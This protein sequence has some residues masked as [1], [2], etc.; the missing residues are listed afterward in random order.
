[1]VDIQTDRTFRVEN[2]IAIAVKTDR[3]RN[4]P[5]K[6]VVRVLEEHDITLAEM[7][8]VIDKSAEE[9]LTNVGIER[10][11]LLKE[12]EDMEKEL[13]EALPTE[14]DVKSLQ[15]VKEYLESEKVRKCMQLLNKQRAIKQADNK[16]AELEKTAADV[17]AWKQQME[18]L[19]AEYLKVNQIP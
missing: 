17:V 11:K 6:N 10:A 16:L 1:M 3:Y 12:R 14:D 8:E 18:G 9:E 19:K 15:E 13:K 7:N 5:G 4:G 2:G